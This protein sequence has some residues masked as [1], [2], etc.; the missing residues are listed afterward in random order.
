MMA[1]DSPMAVE[2]RNSPWAARGARFLRFAT[3]FYRVRCERPEQVY[4]H[5]SRPKHA[6]SGKDKRHV[7]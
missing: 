2:R 1:A 6:L 5:P 4:H 3:G 7:C